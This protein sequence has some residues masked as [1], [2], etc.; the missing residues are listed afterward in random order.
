MDHLEL[1]QCY[2]CKCELMESTELEYGNELHDDIED[3]TSEWPDI[4]FKE[5]NKPNIT[6]GDIENFLQELL[7]NI[8]NDSDYSYE[9][10]NHRFISPGTLTITTKA[11]IHIYIR[12]YLNGIEISV[13][14][15]GC[16][17]KSS[18]QSKWKSKLD[19]IRP[20]IL[21]NQVKIER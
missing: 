16:I 3:L 12:I 17:V 6:L 15:K 2:R 21:P 5:L 10:C 19:S 11:N 18:E 4:E 8:W 20:S 7:I 1:V 14:N 9:W 13:Y